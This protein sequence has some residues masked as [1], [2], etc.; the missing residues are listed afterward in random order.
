M[1]FLLVRLNTKIL[2]LEKKNNI[3]G[4]IL[5]KNHLLDIIINI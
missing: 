5:K 4:L 1:I 3:Y 2:T